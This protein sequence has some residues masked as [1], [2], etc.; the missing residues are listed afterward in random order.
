MEQ[1]IGNVEWWGCAGDF[2][3]EEVGFDIGE[4]TE[5]FGEVVA[6]EQVVVACEE[7]GAVPI[8]VAEHAVADSVARWKFAP[9]VG[10]ERCADEVAWGDRSDNDEVEFAKF[11][12][13]D[14]E[15]VVTSLRA[16]FRYEGVQFAEVVLPFAVERES[17]I[18]EGAGRFE[19]ACRLS[20]EEVERCTGIF[21]FEA[22]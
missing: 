6:G 15:V 19:V 3:T 9:E 13:V 4:A 2:G 11:V 21:L 12:A 14:G 7:G 5:D 18:D 16:A 10:P 17:C 20:T 22:A 1:D 8:V